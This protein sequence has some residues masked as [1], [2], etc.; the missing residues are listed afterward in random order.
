MEPVTSVNILFKFFICLEVQQKE[1]R[2]LAREI[3]AFA[4]FECSTVD[5]ESC[6]QVNLQHSRTLITL[7]DFNEFSQMLLDKKMGKYLRFCGD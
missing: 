1:G 6:R 7:L 3:G 5:P 2:D 4:Y